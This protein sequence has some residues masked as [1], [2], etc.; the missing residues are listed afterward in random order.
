MNIDPM[1]DFRPVW[2]AMMIGGAIAIVV[3]F[4]LRGR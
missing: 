2:Y 3:S 1:K 4:W